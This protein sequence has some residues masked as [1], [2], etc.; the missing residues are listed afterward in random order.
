MADPG[1]DKADI[2]R[3][4]FK[5]FV[6][7]QAAKRLAALGGDLRGSRLGEGLDLRPDRAGARRRW[8]RRRSW[9]RR[10]CR[11]GCCAWTGSRGRSRRRARTGRWRRSRSRCRVEDD[12][13]PIVGIIEGVCRESPGWCVNVESISPTPPA[14]RGSQRGVNHTLSRKISPIRRISSIRSE[15]RCHVIGVGTDRNRT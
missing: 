6:R 7:V 11:R 2:F 9:R 5:T 13:H 12:I 10:R 1:T 14:L 3:E 4:A 8:R 15:V